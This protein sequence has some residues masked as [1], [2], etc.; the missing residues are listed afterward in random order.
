M[1]HRVVLSNGRAL[2]IQEGDKCVNIADEEP[3][4]E[5]EPG[6]YICEINPSGVLV[7]PNSGE[8]TAWVSEGL[9]KTMF[10]PSDPA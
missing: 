5:N 10:H 7:M 4:M 8:A 9:Q 1:I 6:M 3:G 2:L